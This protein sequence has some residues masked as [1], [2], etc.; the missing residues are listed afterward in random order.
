MWP[1]KTKK[2][3]FTCVFCMSVGVVTDLATVQSSLIVCEW[4]ALVKLVASI[5]EPCHCGHTA[6]EACS[7]KQVIAILHDISI[8]YNNI[9]YEHFKNI[10]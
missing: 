3:L 6:W 9:L 5:V 2:N 8:Q 4:L 1:I 10:A 7:H